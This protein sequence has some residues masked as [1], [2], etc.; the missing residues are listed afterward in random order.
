MPARLLPA[1]SSCSPNGISKRFVLTS[2]RFWNYGRLKISFVLK[3]LVFSNFDCPSQ[4]VRFNKRRFNLLQRTFRTIFLSLIGFANE[5]GISVFFVALIC[6]PSFCCSPFI[7]IASYIAVAAF[8]RLSVSF[9]FASSAKNCIPSSFS[10]FLLYSVNFFASQS[11]T[12][13]SR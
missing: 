1:W 5:N 4:T 9:S 3:I 6:Y 12:F 11:P 10:C 13:Q 2:N 8:V 7:S